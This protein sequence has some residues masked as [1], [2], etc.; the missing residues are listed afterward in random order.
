MAPMDRVHDIAGLRVIVLDTSVP[1]H[2]HGE[3][4]GQINCTGSQRNSPNPRP[5]APSSRCTIRRF[6]ACRTSPCR[7]SC[8]TRRRLPGRC[9]APMCAVSSPGTCTTPPRAT[10]AGIPVSVASASC[11]TQ[12][13]LTGG[14]PRARWRPGVQSGALLPRNSGAHR[15]SAGRRSRLSDGSCRRRPCSANWPTAGVS[16]PAGQPDTAY[17]AASWRAHSEALAR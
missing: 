5:S 8:A 6:P 7:S 16:Y 1:G 3:I 15:H 14:N 2:H 17:R 11:Y 9:A 10:F 13:L 4:S 12:D